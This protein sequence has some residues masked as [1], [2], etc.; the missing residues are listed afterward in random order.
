MIEIEK[1][2]SILPTLGG[3]NALN[4]GIE[5]E[6]SGF[7]KE[8]NVRIIGTSALT[9]KRAEDRELFKEAMSY[10]ARY[11]SGLYPLH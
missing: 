10:L 11:S 7:L 9:I 5:L 8:H 3:Q 1:P 4:L 2:D 6:E